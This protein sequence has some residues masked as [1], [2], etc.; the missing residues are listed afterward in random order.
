MTEPA[1]PAR[2]SAHGYDAI[3]RDFDSA[4]MRRMRQEAY[5]EDI[6]QHSWVE[7]E[8]LRVDAQRLALTSSS[9]LLDLGCGPC[10]PLTFVLRMIGC[11]GTG[12]EVSDAALVSGRKRAAALGVAELLTTLQGDLNRPLPFTS[13]SF[14]AVTSLDVVLHVRDRSLLFR[15]VARVLQPGGRFLFTDAGV[16]TGAITAEEVHDRSLHGYTQL[17]PG[18]YNETLLASVGLRLIET[19]DRTESVQRSAHG[20]LAALRAHRT[21]LERS[22]NPQTLQRQE[23]YL[24]TVCELAR[25]RAL[26]RIMY[27]AEVPMTSNIRASASP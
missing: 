19:E 6:G 25:R 11:S 26:S 9:R 14:D 24:E 7:A 21:E 8:H 2:E 17:V 12:I 4:L 15:E 5:G 3:Y 22:S 13:R 10:G 18:G 20:R 23:R 27:L 1:Q 16:V